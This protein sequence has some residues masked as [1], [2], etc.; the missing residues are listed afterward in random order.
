MQMDHLL[1]MVDSD[2]QF[3]AHSESHPYIYIYIDSTPVHTYMIHVQ[4]HVKVQFT[5]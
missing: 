5:G 1:E 4:V 2:I 3:S